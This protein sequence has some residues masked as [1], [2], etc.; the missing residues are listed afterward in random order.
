MS[1]DA[2][3]RAERINALLIQWRQAVDFADEDVDTTGEREHDPCSSS[4]SRAP[5]QSLPAV[6]TLQGCAMQRVS[7]SET[8][9]HGAP[10]GS[11][12]EPNCPI[13]WGIEE[14]R[15]ILEGGVAGLVQVWLVS[16]V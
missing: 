11:Q 14:Y 6:G 2:L 16:V 1:E 8:L 13:P 3:S 7:R 12:L 9:L 15:P 10:T 4:V 5:Q